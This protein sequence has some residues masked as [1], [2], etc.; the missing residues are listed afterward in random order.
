MEVGKEVVRE[1]F[2]E[3][4]NA[5]VAQIQISVERRE[6]RPLRK[7]STFCED[8]CVIRFE[9]SA[10]TSDGSLLSVDH[11]N[12]PTPRSKSGDRMSMNGYSVCQWMS[13]ATAASVSLQSVSEETAKDTP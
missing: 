11:R 10:K 1:Q 5:V 7:S 12:E 8:S 9:N 4:E 2:A 6:N 13:E 3:K